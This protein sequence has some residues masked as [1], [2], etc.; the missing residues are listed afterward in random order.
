M[1]AVPITAIHATVQSAVKAPIR[2]GG[3][4]RWTNFNGGSVME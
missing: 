2:N 1:E 4:N 3:N